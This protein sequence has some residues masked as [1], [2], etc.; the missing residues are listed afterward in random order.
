MSNNLMRAVQAVKA[1]EPF[2]L[3][4][5]AIPEPARGQVRVR[6]HACGVCGGDAIARNGLLGAVLPRVPGHEIAGTVDAV[7]VDVA[8]WKVGDRVGVGWQGGYCKEC[9]FCRAGDFVNCVDS[10]VVGL[11]YDGGYAEYMVAP[12]EA[13]ARIPEELSF[14]EAG[15]MM[16]AGITTFNA[17]RHCGARPGDTVA[18][19]GIGGLGHLAVQFADRMGFRTIAINRKRDKEALSRKLGADDYIDS[20]AGSAGETLMK[21]GAPWQFCPPPATRRRRWT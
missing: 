1:G 8:N 19:H 18:I 16:C 13:L 5:I 15:P 20:T 2:V 14:E 3:G 21:M 11:S 12:Q 10:Q 9:Q 7:G 6:V 4:E 17:L